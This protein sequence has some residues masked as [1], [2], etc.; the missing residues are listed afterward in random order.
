[1]SSSSTTGSILATIALFCMCLAAFNVG[2][3]RNNKANSIYQVSWWSV[4]SAVCLFLSALFIFF[5][6]D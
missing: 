4:P 5:A 1:M 6:Y 2:R 3:Q